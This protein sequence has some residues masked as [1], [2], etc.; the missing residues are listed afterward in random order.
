M[1]CHEDVAQAVMLIL[2]V[3]ILALLPYSNQKLPA[4]VCNRLG[5][6]VTSAPDH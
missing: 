1:D 4:E 6:L 2:L 3:D 5:Q